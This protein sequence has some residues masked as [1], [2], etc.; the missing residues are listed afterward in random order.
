[1]K[2][3]SPRTTRGKT[4]Q[5]KMAHYTDKSGGDDACHLWTGPKNGWGY[6]VVCVDG[7]HQYAHRAAY[8]LAYGADPDGKHV[9]HN[10][11]NSACVNPS[12]LRTGTD[13]D[14]MNDWDV[15][16]DRHHQAKVPDCVVADV[17]RRYK[18]GNV[19]QQA[20]A[21]E[22]TELGWPTGRVTVTDWING[23]WRSK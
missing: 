7:K 9:L 13:K 19:T 11:F 16:G 15:T 21:T 18:V 23:K 3:R 8:K 22:L 14:N 1:M 10:C 2:R 12:H 5:E 4:L 6:G 20:L 17:I